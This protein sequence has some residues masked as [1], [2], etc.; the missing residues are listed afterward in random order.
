MTTLLTTWTVKS[1]KENI[2]LG[3]RETFADVSATILDILELEKLDN[4][5][6]FKNE[7]LK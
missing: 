6:S 4:G 2:N 5:K 1:V 3:I 7:I